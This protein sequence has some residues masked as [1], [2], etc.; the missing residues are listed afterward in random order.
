MRTSLALAFLALALCAPVHAAD[1]PCSAEK[2]RQIEFLKSMGATDVEVT[3]DTCNAAGKEAARAKAE[4][5]AKKPKVAIIPL[6]DVNA[7]EVP[8]RS[9]SVGDFDA[10][11]KASFLY[12]YDK[13]APHYYRGAVKGDPGCALQLAVMYLYGMGV[14]QDAAQGHAWLKVAFVDDRIVTDRSMRHNF[15]VFLDLANNWSFPE[16]NYAVGRA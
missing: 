6:I 12:G 16:A 14:R 10:G 5:E 3:G 15:L 9:E 13:A 1:D 4:A 2:Q 8:G 11:M 7:P